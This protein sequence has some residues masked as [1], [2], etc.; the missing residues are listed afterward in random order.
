VP[1]IV[2]SADCPLSRWIGSA[3]AQGALTTAVAA[4]ATANITADRD[5]RDMPRRYARWPTLVTTLVRP[6]DPKYKISP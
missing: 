6:M 5:R 3:T 2:A 4:A 1:S